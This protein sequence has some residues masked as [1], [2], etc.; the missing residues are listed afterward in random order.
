[1]HSAKGLEFPVVFLV[2]LVE[3]EFPTDTIKPHEL[4]EERRLFLVGITRAR[5]RLCLCSH[6]KDESGRATERS[7]FI[8][9]AFA[10]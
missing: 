2:G 1:V 7:R 8:R 10:P 4:A 6:E 9:E 3:G 5:E